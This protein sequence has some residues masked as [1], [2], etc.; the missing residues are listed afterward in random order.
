MDVLALNET[1]RKFLLSLNEHG[2]RYLVVGMSAALIQGARGLTED[3][4]LWFENLGDSR[5]HDAAV[6]VGGFWISGAFGMRPPAFGG[7]QLA[8]R[9]DVI[10]HMH[11]LEDF[12]TE[13]KNAH[14][15]IVDGIPLRV[16]PL[17]RIILSKRT[18]NRP[19]DQA[20][21]PALETALAVK[22]DESDRDRE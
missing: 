21:L 12:S 4:D 2:V 18:A 3:I 6:E 8:D 17:G 9:F 1:E 13:Y 11:G 15:E 20:Q 5:I 19:K 22:K 7:D 14:A 16:L 10:T